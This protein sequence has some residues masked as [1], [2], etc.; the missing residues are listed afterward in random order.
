MPDAMAFV[1]TAVI[2]RLRF[3]LYRDFENASDAA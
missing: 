1:E 2:R 3:W